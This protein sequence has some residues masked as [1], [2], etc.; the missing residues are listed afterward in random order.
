MTRRL[1][2][3]AEKALWRAAMQDVRP[4]KKKPAHKP[5]AKPPAGPE[6]RPATP[7]SSARARPKP[8][9]AP[10]S[11]PAARPSGPPPDL[12]HGQAT[13][14]DRRSADRLR[15]GRL[16]IDGRL[17]LHGLT[18]AVAVQRL[19]EFIAGGHAAGKRCLLVITGKGLARGGAG[20]LREQVP[21]WLNQAPNR[22]HVL[23]FTYAQPQHG[24]MGAL[25]VLLKRRR[26]A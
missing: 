26:E 19:A 9:A 16:V 11:P 3:E 20:V 13:G 18:Q 23:A 24:G 1:P 10:S 6:A 14:L 2:S 25:Y 7:K 12:A 4:L 15:R 21:R 22:A 5:V 8:A 17:D